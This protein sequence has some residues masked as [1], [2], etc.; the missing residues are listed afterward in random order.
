M[1]PLKIFD[2]NM[3][4]HW[5]GQPN[6]ILT[7]NKRLNAR[8]HEVIIA[9]PKDC[10]LCKRAAEAGIETFDDLELRR[11][12]RLR[13]QY[14]DYRNMKRL[15]EERHFDLVH[16]HGSQDTWLAAIAAKNCKPPIPVVR[17][18]HNTFPISR[19]PLNRWLYEK[20]IDRVITISPQ[21]DRY[22]TEDG[23]FPAEHV[24]PIYSA[25]DGERFHPDIDG[26]SVR[27]E[28]GIPQDV[29]VIGMV[30]RYA[31][32]KG[33]KDLINAAAIVVKEFPEV[34]FV[35]VGKGRSEPEM[36]EQIAS[37][38]LEDNFILTGF[39]TDVPQVVSTFDIF[40]LTPIS[41]ESLGTSIL[42]AFLEEKPV[43]ATDV[44][45]VCQSVRDGQTGFL[46]PPHSPQPLADSYLRLLRD[47]ELRRQLG[48]HGRQMVLAEFNEA[49]LADKT[50]KL[51]CEILGFINGK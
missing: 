19:H 42:E 22:L 12:L 24:V 40:T 23:L 30:G 50:E 11:G 28:L 20:L 18:R 7:Y 10:L 49:I 17:T 14:R 15:F 8:G 2:I 35:L 3:H 47:P 45:G 36:R 32:E 26:S 5:G 46:V 9:G 16:T 43:I 29:P 34:R 6:R 33:H 48:Q 4:H 44:G 39:R 25:P 37:L 1:R 27:E 21:V 41:G 13:S 51:Y 38:G 31:P